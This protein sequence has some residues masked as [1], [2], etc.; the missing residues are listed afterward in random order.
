MPQFHIVTDITGIFF[1]F[2]FKDFFVRYLAALC[3]LRLL[4]NDHVFFLK[5]I[6]VHHCQCLYIN[7]LYR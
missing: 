3:G 4:C 2:F 5:Y 1:F 7:I 6:L